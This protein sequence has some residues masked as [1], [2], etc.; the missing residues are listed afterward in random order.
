[1]NPY[2]IIAACIAWGASVGGAFVFGT[3]VG[4]DSEIAGQ[5]KI[6]KAITDTREAAQQGAADEIAKIKPVNTTIVQKTQREIQRE[7]V[8]STCRVTPDGVRLAN[9][10]IT[11]KSAE[12]VGSEQLP[13]S[14]TPLR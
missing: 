8:Y 14:I 13:P 9:E 11:G 2:L 6:N 7:T 4:K 5:A 3:E 12:P 10:A 1:M